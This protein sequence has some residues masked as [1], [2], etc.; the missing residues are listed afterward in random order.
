MH[1][2]R[3]PSRGGRGKLVEWTEDP[4]DV[5][6]GIGLRLAVTRL[7][8]LDDAGESLGIDATLADQI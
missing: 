1:R 4:N 8:G 2:R 5:C 3:Q 7:K 6:F